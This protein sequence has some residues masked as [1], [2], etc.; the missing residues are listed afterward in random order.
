MAVYIKKDL[1]AEVCNVSLSPVDWQQIKIFTQHNQRVL[2]IHHVYNP[3]T[4]LLRIPPI[5]VKSK[6]I[7]LGDFNSHSKLWGYKEANPSG[8]AIEEFIQSNPVKL[9]NTPLTEKTLHHYATGKEYN[10]DL[11]I[12]SIDMG[13]CDRKVLEC[14]GSD[15]LPV[16]LT[17]QNNMLRS[18]DAAQS[19]RFNYKKANWSKFTILAENYVGKIDIDRLGLEKSSDEITKQLK[20]AQ[21]QSVPRGKPPHFRPNIPGEVLAIIKERQCAR[22]AVRKH[23][24]KE[25]KAN[26]NRLSD[27]VRKSMIKQQREE[28]R[29][30]CEGIN[31]DTKPGKVWKL[32]KAMERPRED[33][34]RKSVAEL[35]GSP[36]QQAQDFARH[37][38]SITNEQRKPLDRLITWKKAVRTNVPQSIFESNFTDAELGEAISHLKANK[39]PGPDRIR[40]ELLMHLGPAARKVLLNLINLTWSLGKTPKVWR[41]ATIVPVLKPGK[42]AGLMD[43]YRPI[44]LTSGIAKI[45][46]RMVHARLQWHIETHRLIDQRQAAFRPKKSTTDQLCYFTQRAQN[47]FEAKSNTVMVA[48][49]L[50]K[51]YDRVWRDGLLHKLADIGI[52]GNMYK[53]ISAQIKQR[54]ICVKVD[55]VESKPRRHR[56]GIPQG[57]VLSC[58]LFNVFLSDLPKTHNV[59]QTLFADDLLLHVSGRDNTFMER[60][61]N[62]AI[63]SID[64]FA[65]LWKLR[66]N[67]DK[68]AYSVMSKSAVVPKLKLRLGQDDIRFEANIKYLGLIFD[69]SLT[70]AQHFDYVTE[71]A[72][73]R[74]NILRHLAGTTWGS[75]QEVL[76]NLYLSFI[77]PILDYGSELFVCASESQLKKLYVIQ[78]RCLNVI[79]GTMRSTPNAAKE[80]LA[81]IPP[82]D[83]HF[84]Q[85]RMCLMEKYKRLPFDDRN[86]RLVYRILPPNRL[87][88]ESFLSRTKKETRSMATNRTPLQV[89]PNEPP[90]ERFHVGCVLLERDF[91]KRNCTPEQALTIFS[92]ILSERYDP[93]VYVKVYTDGSRMDGRAGIGVFVRFPSGSTVEISKSAGNCSN[94]EAELHAILEACTS[95]RANT[96][97][98]F[99][100][101]I[102]VFSD[103]QAALAAI[104][105]SA[106]S[107]F[108]EEKVRNG[109]RELSPMSVTLQYIPAHVGLEGN[110]IADRLAK[111]GVNEAE[112][113]EQTG[114]TF[115][116]A[117]CVI[118]SRLLKEW[119]HRWAGGNSGRSLYDNVPLPTASLQQSRARLPR[120]FSSALN[121]AST[122][123]IPLRAFLSKFKPLSPTCPLCGQGDQTVRHVLWSC[124]AQRVP[125]APVSLFA[126]ERE[127]L[128][129]VGAC[130]LRVL[131]GAQE[132][133]V[134]PRP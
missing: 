132:E 125:V 60:S 108:L 40:N 22:K 119:G 98:S 95:L 104:T 73:K 44:S 116:S 115:E 9:L 90:H 47:S 37:F 110:E 13:D 6:T 97:A 34:P 55:A 82:L 42:P 7:L 131:K 126:V 85:K 21:K 53:W 114:A 11:D 12:V 30:K 83:L 26:Y 100:T 94:Y 61:L 28:W 101:P 121:R 84:K 112:S 32:V 38:T 65:R 5:D 128:T 79:L 27:L 80:I 71:K 15:H 17:V 134:S 16:L 76:R 29:S 57:S 88:Q 87:T 14:I 62:R 122:G 103:S 92:Q 70:M 1:I 105:R 64:V 19:T 123:H 66:I 127:K 31:K 33:A 63:A 24:T 93:E 43:S 50:S 81:N 72:S 54:E 102:V 3:P 69:K 10:P 113:V 120:K 2:T 86:R 96:Y 91:N 78:N 106:A 109:I 25:N 48:L 89:C 99:L 124:D 36:F 56:V 35:D 20:R 75:E 133:A 130:L 23:P 107:T 45:A 67:P 118:A 8:K 41:R 52:C 77:R 117:K 18:L 46:E 129:A 39:A 4:N 74:A 59:A 111:K 68:C 51:A 58:L 49:D